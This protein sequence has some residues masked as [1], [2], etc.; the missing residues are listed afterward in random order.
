MQFH[1]RLH[2]AKMFVNIDVETLLFRCF[3]MLLFNFSSSQNILFRNYDNIYLVNRKF[4]RLHSQM[5]LSTKRIQIRSRCGVG[6]V[7]MTILRR[8]FSTCVIMWFSLVHTN[9]HVIRNRVE[10]PLLRLYRSAIRVYKFESKKRK[11]VDLEI[12]FTTA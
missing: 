5:Y 11:S 3:D 7:A 4:Y 6:F 2:C 12:V 1:C 8:L 9:K 10:D